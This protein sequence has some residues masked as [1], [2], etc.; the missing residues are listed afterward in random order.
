MKTLSQAVKC[1]LCPDCGAWVVLREDTAMRSGSG[2]RSHSLVHCPNPNCDQPQFRVKE[3]ELHDFTLAAEML[4]RE[5]FYPSD[6]RDRAG[7]SS[8][9]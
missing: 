2:R 9:L 5:Y 3:E 4:E 1:A 6:I 7:H 8:W